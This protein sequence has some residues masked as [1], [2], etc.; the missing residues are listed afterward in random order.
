MLSLDAELSGSVDS[1]FT[2]LS[3]PK[4]DASVDSWRQAIPHLAAQLC[5]HCYLQ[6]Y[7]VVTDSGPDRIVHGI[8]MSNVH[9]FG[10]FQYGIWFQAQT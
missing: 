4:C 3:Q 8:T 1:V 7:F 6:L 2:P 10:A 9:L 5:V